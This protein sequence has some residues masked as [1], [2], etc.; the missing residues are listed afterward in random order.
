MI[1]SQDYSGYPAGQDC[2]SSVRHRDGMT[3]AGALNR[4]SL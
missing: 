3:I 2:H 4:R 1:Q